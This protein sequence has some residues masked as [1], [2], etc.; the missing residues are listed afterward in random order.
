[1]QRLTLAFVLL[2]QHCSKEL[3]RRARQMGCS[4]FDG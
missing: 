1:M 4:V 2:T 3:K